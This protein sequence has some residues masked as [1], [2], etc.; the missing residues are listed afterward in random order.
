MTQAGCCVK[1]DYYHLGNE[2]AHL[3]SIWIQQTKLKAVKGIHKNE[4]IL[5]LKRCPSL[6]CYFSSSESVK[7]NVCHEVGEAVCL[8]HC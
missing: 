5:K 3:Q 8:E 7:C 1:D 2:S 4:T 6:Y